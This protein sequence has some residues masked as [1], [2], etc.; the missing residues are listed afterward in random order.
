MSNISL[1]TPIGV[2]TVDEKDKIVFKNGLYAF[3][4]FRNAYI[5]SQ[6]EHQTFE[7]LIAEGFPQ[8]LFVIIK[9]YL[10]KKDYILDIREE[11]LKEIGISNQE[12]AEE[13]LEVYS[14]VT[15]S[16]DSLTA[17]LLGP[18]IINMKEKIGKQAL[19]ANKGYHTKHDIQE[20]FKKTYSETN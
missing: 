16:E 13:F 18:V 9:P 12:E 6:D 19:A 14:I 20:E 2:F 11:D 1:E 3:E 5:V 7:Y 17:N 4:D 15:M 10:F 8:T